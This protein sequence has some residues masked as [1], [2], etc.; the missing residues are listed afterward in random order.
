LLFKQDVN[1][2]THMGYLLAP[3]E[4]L[5]NEPQHS[6]GDKIALGTGTVAGAG[7]GAGAIAL[8]AGHMFHD[9]L[10][11]NVL[12][13]DPEYADFLASR[14]PL[15]RAYIKSK[16]GLEAVYYTLKDLVGKKAIDAYRSS[17]EKG[18]KRLKVAGEEALAY[19]RALSAMT[20]KK[21]KVL[22]ALGLPAIAAAGYGRYK[23]TEAL[24]D[25]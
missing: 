11:R 15:K 19:T 24:L 6:L 25:D 12:D 7:L 18:L 3:M 1:K 22:A 13:P 23:G 21:V 20:P 4:K 2:I 8:P 9:H 5:A 16:T 14:N 10:V 17:P